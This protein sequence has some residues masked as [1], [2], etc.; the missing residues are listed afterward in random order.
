M[1]EEKN[2]NFV[3]F[4]CGLFSTH[5]MKGNE[6]IWPLAK[7][8]MAR[9]YY[10][11]RIK[12]PLKAI[13]QPKKKIDNEISEL[14]KNTMNKL[15]DKNLT[16]GKLMPYNDNIIKLIKKIVGNNYCIFSY[17][18]RKNFN[19][20]VEDFAKTIH[21]LKTDA[22]NIIIISHSAGGIISYQYLC[23]EELYNTGDNSNFSKIKKFITIGCPIQGSSKALST[24][25]GVCNQSVL[26]QKEIEFIV[27]TG[28][29]ESIFQLLPNNIAN[30]FVDKKTKTLINDE[31]Q[32]TKILEYN[33]ISKDFI[34]LILSYKEQFLQLKQ[35]KN[36][37]HLFI[38]G[39]NPDTS[40]CTEYLVDPDS[41][42]IECVY[43]YGA[44]DGT[45]LTRESVPI[46]RNDNR[47]RT[48]YVVGK[49]CYL[50]E[51]DETLGIIEDELSNI[52]TPKYII[53]SLTINHKNKIL[54]FK[55]YLV[56]NNEKYLIT[57]FC[58]ERIIFV[59]KEQS[60]NITNTINKY[61]KS[62]SFYFKTNKKYG[63]LK[64]RNLK[65]F[66]NDNI[67]ENENDFFFSNEREANFDE[68]I[69][70]SNSTEEIYNDI[71]NIPKR[72]IT[73]VFIKKIN[74]E[75][76]ISEIESLF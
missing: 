76:K 54:E 7:Q 52:D 75:I 59:N 21:N 32:I 20:L 23:Q 74:I 26:T 71:K 8:D 61:K 30:L 57:D 40:M 66:F 45:V 56:K 6:T 50:T 58:A 4:V 15:I 51:Y 25:L 49:H 68:G 41:L 3:V 69:F 28:N 46:N 16:P 37:D 53:E 29:F 62:N 14:I 38:V 10:T 73:N 11:N 13:F 64:F 34:K 27:K 18:W 22:E 24:I 35:N 55:L 42:D 2:K 19:S 43:D 48:R 12:N 33:H 70:E 39:T 65:V 1:N 72:N 9:I 17:D 5:L 63:I 67:N 60:E 47:Y 36:V 44:G 31:V